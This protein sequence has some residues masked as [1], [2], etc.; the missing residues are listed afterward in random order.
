MRLRQIHQQDL[1]HPPLPGRPLTA[2][3]DLLLG[4]TGLGQATVG[5]EAHSVVTEIG[6]QPGA[7]LSGALGGLAVSVKPV[8]P[9]LSFQVGHPD[10]FGG[11]RQVGFADAHG[12]DLVVVGMRL[13]E[14]A[15][16]TALQDLGLAPDRREG[17]HDL[18]AVARSFQDNQICFGGVLFGPARQPAHGDPVIDFFHDRSGR[19]W[20]PDHRAGE[21]VRVSVQA[22]HSLD[23]FDWC[24]HITFYRYAGGRSRVRRLHALRYSGRSPC[25]CFAPVLIHGNGE[26]SKRIPRASP[27]S[28]PA[29]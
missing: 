9:L 28:P 2:L 16:M 1:N 14:L 15:Q 25:R 10:F 11:A 24:V 20:P 5:F 21:T 17:A 22:D 27:V 3:A 23:R 19:G 29:G 18:E 13:L 8:A 6:A 7:E 4:R 26:D 12:A